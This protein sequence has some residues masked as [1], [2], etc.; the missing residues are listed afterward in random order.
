MATNL[1]GKKVLIT[2]GPTWVAIDNVR[3]ISNTATGET[4]I[5][6]A[7]KFTQQGSRVTLLLGPVGAAGLDG[8]IKL[9]R[10]S[11]FDELSIL[12]TKELDKDY[13]IVIHAAAVSDFKPISAGNKKINSRVKILKLTFKPTPKIINCLREINPRSFLVGFKFE[14]DLTT[15]KLIKEARNLIKEAALDLAVANSARNSRYSAYL[16]NAKKS[17]GPFLSKPQMAKNL[18]KLI[19]R[20]YARS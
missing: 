15:K 4:G 11:Y 20:E 2:S 16:V 18:L 1:K 13:D 7:N 9:K 3:V 10:F 14:P 17:Y 6:L 12:L 19:G 8:K 5:L